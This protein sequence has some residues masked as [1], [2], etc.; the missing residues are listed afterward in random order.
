MGRVL[1]FLVQVLERA[2]FQE[3]K[4]EAEAAARQG[5]RRRGG[6]SE[7]RIGALSRLIGES[8]G[9]WSCSWLFELGNKTEGFML[10]LRVCLYENLCIDFS[11]RLWSLS[12]TLN[13]VHAT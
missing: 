11:W 4:G 6:Q 3:A 2:A 8:M 10:L 1:S 12:L 13:K 9:V 7:G 5:R